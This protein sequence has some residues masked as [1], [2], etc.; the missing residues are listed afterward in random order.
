MYTLETKALTSCETFGVATRVI[1]RAARSVSTIMKR[2]HLSVAIAEEPEIQS[3]FTYPLWNESLRG[4]SANAAKI[5]ASF[6]ALW[7]G[8]MTARARMETPVDKYG[9]E[10]LRD[11]NAS[12]AV[13]RYHT[14]VA[15]MLSPQS[16]DEKTKEVGQ[17]KCPSAVFRLLTSRYR[18]WT[19]CGRRGS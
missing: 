15:L 19:I 11:V 8:I 18:Q 17:D 3:M 13:Q 7:D 1:A 2:K 4:E 10:R 12:P 6:P 5:P 16:K 14:L 9:C